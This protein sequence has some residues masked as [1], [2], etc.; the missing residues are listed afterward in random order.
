MCHR[1]RSTLHLS[2]NAFVSSD[3]S[4]KTPAD[5]SEYRT[6]LGTTIPGRV[7]TLWIELK[8]VDFVSHDICLM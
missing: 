1:R 3:T 2:I 7:I 6:V 5:M 8:Q 4:H